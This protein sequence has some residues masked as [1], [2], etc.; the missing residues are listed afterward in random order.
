MRIPVE[1]KL[2]R[3]T[4]V[5]CAAMMI[6]GQSQ[7]SSPQPSPAPIPDAT[8]TA[9]ALDSLVAPIALYPDTLVAQVLAAA[10]YPLQIVEANRWLKTNN[11]LR[12]SALVQ[13]AAKQDWEP[14]IQA[15]VLF[16]SVLNQMDTN[17]KWTTALGNAFLAQQEDVMLA[18][19]RQRMKAYAGGRLSSNVQQKVEVQQAEGTKVIVIQPANP[20]VIYIPTYNPTVVFGAAPVYYPYPAIVYPPP[21]RGEVAAASAVSFGVGVMV[22]A[23]LGGWHGQGWGWGCNWGPRPTLYVNNTFINRYGFR[24]PA[25]ARPYGNVPWTHSPYYRG[26][27]PYSSS[28]VANRYRAGRPVATPYG[29]AAGMRAPGGAAGAVAGR[30]RGAAAVT[31]PR[32]SAGVVTGPRGTAGAIAGPNQGAAAVNTPRRSDG[33]VT[34]PGGTAGAVAGPNR[35][36]AAVDTPRRTVGVAAGP[37]R[38]A[39]AV[40]TPSGE[41][42]PIATPQ[43]TAS[44][45]PVSGG[46]PRGRYTNPKPTAFG[47]GSY[48]AGQSSARGNASM[49]RRR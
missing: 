2:F 4:A 27:V 35:G 8:L 48:S 47:G 32:G 46:T 44:R 1:I 10:T 12:D 29:G 24:A 9:E 26:A 36:A 13:A 39:G 49:G 20:E 19:Q 15:L 41:G 25:Y 38:A 42:G 28:T 33:V 30:N 21:S 31:S 6:P 23:A 45:S 40:R 17:L 5:L 14:S 11:S 43:G 22:G 34:G 16:A 7:A 3:I 37:N 18:V